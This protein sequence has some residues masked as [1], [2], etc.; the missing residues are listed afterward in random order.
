MRFEQSIYIIPYFDFYKKFGQQG[1]CVFSCS[2]R[3]FHN[4][5]SNTGVGT[6]LPFS[7]WMIQLLSFVSAFTLG[8]DGT[9]F[10]FLSEG[11]IAEPTSLAV[12][13]CVL[14]SEVQGQCVEG[15]IQG[16]SIRRYL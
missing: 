7:K 3:T 4:F 14:Q 2:I 8:C 13:R 10:F 1:A 11:F 12:I 6:H 5:V 16:S 9:G 15:P